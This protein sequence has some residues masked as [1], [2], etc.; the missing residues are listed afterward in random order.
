MKVVTNASVMLVKKLGLNY[1]EAARRATKTRAVREA[2]IEPLRQ[3]IVRAYQS[4]KAEKSYDKT[5]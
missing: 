4:T 2:K 1:R 5:Y 3:R